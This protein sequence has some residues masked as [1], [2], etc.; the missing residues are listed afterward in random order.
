MSWLGGNELA[1]YGAV[2][3]TIALLITFFGY[4]YNVKKDQIKLSLSYADHPNKSKNIECLY[5]DNSEKPWDQAKLV[6]VYTVT[7]R[8]LGSIPAPLHDVGVIDKD[9]KKYQALVSHPMSHTILLQSLTESDN[10]PLKPRAA[11]TFSV[12]LRRGEPFFLPVSAYAIDQTG[13]EWKVSA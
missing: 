2:I 8:N 12:Y 9:G 3:A 10:E 11:K 4:R 1:L 5:T 7:V 13:K 6:E